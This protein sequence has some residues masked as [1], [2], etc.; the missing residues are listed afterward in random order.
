M[1]VGGEKI[2]PFH[3]GQFFNA[4]SIIGYALVALNES[5][6]PFKLENPIH[7]GFN[8]DQR[9][10][11]VM[12]PGSSFEDIRVLMFVFNFEIFRMFRMTSKTLL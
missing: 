9:S 1:P 5:P 3:F 10:N 8:P 2:I 11:F 4:R 6:L 12:C 7:S